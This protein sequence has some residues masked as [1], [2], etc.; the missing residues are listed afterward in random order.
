ML[1]HPCQDSQL[2]QSRVLPFLTR[3]SRTR[4]SRA[5]AETETRMRVIVSLG[6]EF[7]R[8]QDLHVLFS[9]QFDLVKVRE[10]PVNFYKESFSTL[11]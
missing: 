6:L 5:L 11:A 7:R 1:R 3:G 8:C 10:V 2:R 9:L 4:Q